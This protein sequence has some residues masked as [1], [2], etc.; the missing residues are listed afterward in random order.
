MRPPEVS[1]PRGVD[2]WIAELCAFGT[3]VQTFTRLPVPAAVGWS[4]AQARAA[5]R[6]LPWVGLLVGA[7]AALVYWGAVQAWPPGVAVLGSMVASLC[8][9]GA[10][11]EDGLADTADGLG[12]GGQDRA[13]VLAILQDPRV[14]SFGVVALV[15]ALA[16][17]AQLLL[18]LP[19]S[20][21]PGVLVAAH[22]LS[23]V[24]AL[25]VMVC[26][27]YLRED[28]ASKS[29]AMAAQRLSGASFGVGALAGALACLGLVMFGVL[30][31]GRVAAMVLV[32]GVAAGLAV[33]AL[34]RR[35][36]GYVGDMLGAAQQCTEL[37]VLAVCAAGTGGVSNA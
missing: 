12:G 37:W 26:L 4:P 5:V 15:M 19:P 29:R 28:G 2:R 6:Y 31:P 30:S 25:W 33:V 16:L 3:A 1:S 13:R 9:T 24:S 21:V 8:L 23:R 36:G 20:V 11:H 34:R 14:G 27:P 17:K 35:L 7:V 18:A 22:A 32:T 10:M